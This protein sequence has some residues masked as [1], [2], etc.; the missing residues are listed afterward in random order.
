[1]S[2][3]AEIS[4]RAHT[5]AI[6]PLL[7]VYTQV[8]NALRESRHCNVANL[9]EVHEAPQATHAL[10]EYCAGGSVHR[11]LRSLRH[12]QA[13]PEAFGALLTSQLS[14]ALAHLHSLGIAHRDVKPENVLYTDASRTA[15]KL[16]DF[17]FGAR[18]TSRGAAP[19][20]A[21]PRLACYPPF[22]LGYRLSPLALVSHLALLSRH[23]SPPA[24]HCCAAIVCG[25][26][27]LRTVC[28]SPAYMA[29]VRVPSG[30]SCLRPPCPSYLR[31]CRVFPC[32]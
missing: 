23:H 3:A 2:S 14:G 12:G 20:L 11:H 32:A 18:A 21:L 9:L 5:C 25:D 24:M 16:C 1:M 29:P 19:R 10:L 7:L 26:R 27:K 13:F 6:V 17:G 22:R 8:L 4:R 15:I 30:A 28:G 31:L